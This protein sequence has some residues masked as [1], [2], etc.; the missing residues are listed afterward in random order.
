MKHKV[1]IKPPYKAY[2]DFT[3]SRLNN[4]L[5]AAQNDGVPLGAKVIIKNYFL[6]DMLK[7][8]IF[9]WETK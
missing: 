2:E 5:T 9:K 7:K 6:S 4:V 8:V 3:L 1:V